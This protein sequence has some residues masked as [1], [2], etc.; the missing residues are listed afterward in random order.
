MMR[1]TKVPAAGGLSAEG[2]R[3]LMPLVRR[4]EMMELIEEVMVGLQW[5]G[6]CG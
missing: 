3:P 6:L 1:R 4:E 2:T 5:G